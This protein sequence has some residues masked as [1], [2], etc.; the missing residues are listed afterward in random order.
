MK[1][2]TASGAPG[3]TRS[4]KI[5]ERPGSPVARREVEFVDH[6][7]RLVAIKQIERLHSPVRGRRSANKPRKTELTGLLDHLM[8]DQERRAAAAPVGH[9][10]KTPQVCINIPGDE[11]LAADEPDPADNRA[12]A[13]GDHGPGLAILNCRSQ[14]LGIELDIGDRVVRKGDFGDLTLELG[15]DGDVRGCNPPECDS[16]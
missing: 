15:D 10:I 14:F 5:D 16:V 12:V 3:A 4:A 1:I 11:V 9:D 6:M 7:L 8:H 2:G 13:F